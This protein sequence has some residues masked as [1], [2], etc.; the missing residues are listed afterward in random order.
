MTVDNA[1]YVLRVRLEQQG[2]GR[3]LARQ[4]A[5]APV[6]G[7]AATATRAGE[8][9]TFAV[10]AVGEHTAVAA[11]VLPRGFAW[12][13]TFRLR[14]RANAAPVMTTPLRA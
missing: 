13:L 2:A 10:L 6:Q 4:C 1:G 7:W 8:S 3:V 12:T 5:T 11:A 14:T 9:V